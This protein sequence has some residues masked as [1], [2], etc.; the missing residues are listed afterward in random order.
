M[1]ILSDLE[2]NTSLQDLEKIAPQWAKVLFA[3]DEFHECMEPNDNLNI[4]SSTTC[5]VGEAH[6]F[7]NLYHDCHICSNY[8]VRF[9]RITHSTH[10]YTEKW[11]KHNKK[12]YEKAWVQLD[13]F[14]RHFK[15]N[16]SKDKE[17]AS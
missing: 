13:R 11:T 2:K 6:G 9:T 16:H 1:K 10:A 12:E 5:I 7:N 3:S 14:I 8:N 17:Q 15:R 4:Y